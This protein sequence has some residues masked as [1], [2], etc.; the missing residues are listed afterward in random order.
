MKVE[1]KIVLFNWAQGIACVSGPDW[2]IPVP[3]TGRLDSSAHIARAQLAQKSK[4]HPPSRDKLRESFRKQ[5]WDRASKFFV[6]LVKLTHTH[7]HTLKQTFL[8]LC[9]KKPRNPRRTNHCLRLQWHKEA[10]EVRCPVPRLSQPS[11]PKFLPAPI[12]PLPFTSLTT[13][14]P[15]HANPPHPGSPKG[16][17]RISG[18]ISISWTFASDFLV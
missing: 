2:Y 9:R 3:D 6:F 4:R 13:S 14:F 5:V 7:T 15:H 11:V 1:W 17:F 12:S 16:N 10:A 8:F 18:A